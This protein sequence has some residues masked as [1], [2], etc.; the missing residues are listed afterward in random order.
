M[1]TK[2]YRVYC[3]APGQKRFKAV[4]SYGDGGVCQVDRLFYAYYWLEAQKDHAIRFL[5]YA[6]EQAPEYEWELRYC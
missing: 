3:K 6:R 5:E 4:G 1:K 2:E